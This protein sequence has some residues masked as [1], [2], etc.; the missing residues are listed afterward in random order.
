MPFNGHLGLG[1][2]YKVMFLS[3]SVDVNFVSNIQD[4]YNWLVEGIVT[5]WVWLVEGLG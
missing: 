4:H 1:E 2:H 3:L 5:S